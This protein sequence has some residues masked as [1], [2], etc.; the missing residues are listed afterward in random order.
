MDFHLS[1]PYYFN[2]KESHLEEEYI[3]KCLLCDIPNA[4]VRIHMDFCIDN[5]CKYCAYQECK[6]RKENI[7][8]KPEWNEEKLLG[9]PIEPKGH[10]S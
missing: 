3:E 9:A 2:I 4:Q 5:L 8:N 10:I 7:I 1:L 6:V